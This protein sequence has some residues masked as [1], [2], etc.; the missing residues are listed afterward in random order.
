MHP[1][2]HSILDWYHTAKRD[3]P[4]RNT[5][6]PYAIWLSEVILQQTRVDQGLPYYQKFIENFPNVCDLA[7]A[8]EDEVLRL[9]Q[10]LGY[11]SRARNLHKCAKI[12]KE[13]YKGKFPNQYSKL[14]KLPG[15]GKY[16]ASAIASISGGESTPVIDGNVY[17]VVT[18]YYALEDDI[19]NS[20][21]Y[22]KI[23]EVLDKIIPE[24]DPG[25]FNQAIME[26][27]ATVCMPRNPS[28]N[29][30][31]WRLGCVA[32]ETS[33]IERFPIKTKKTKVRK[34]VFNYL[35]IENAGKLQLRKRGVTDIWR[36][37]YDFPVIESEEALPVSEL[38]RKLPEEIRKESVAMESS[39]TYQH[40]LSHQKISATFHLI[41]SG[42]K[43]D[44]SAQ[45]FTRE[46]IEKLPKPVL[47]EKY[48]NDH[49][50]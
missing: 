20:K 11:Y 23:L 49:S 42:K 29:E 34:R 35:V 22:S 8:S 4:W 18:R 24:T 7:S 40:I 45:W 50:I 46:E 36:G 31:P 47:I 19:S 13:E 43:I 25:E 26:L 28:C 48:L 32:R 16:T 41:Q 10:G 30:C 37:L 3:L 14:I 9:W 1:L 12:V 5:D 27:G 39:P 6:D 15:I 38:K 33:Q 2:A 21:T 44:D 17:R